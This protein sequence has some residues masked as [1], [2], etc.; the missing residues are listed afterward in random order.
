MI[1]NAFHVYSIDDSDVIKYV[2]NYIVNF[3]GNCLGHSVEDYIQNDAGSDV[4]FY[5]IVI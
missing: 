5:D 2:V 3:T 4:L 1:I